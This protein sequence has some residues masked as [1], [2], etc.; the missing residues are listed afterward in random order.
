MAV[1]QRDESFGDAMRPV[2]LRMEEGQELFTVQDSAFQ[3]RCRS[4]RCATCYITQGLSG[5]Y[6]R[7]NGDR[8]AVDAFFG[9]L[10]THIYH[11]N[12]DVESCEYMSRQLGKSRRLRVS[13]S[14]SRKTWVEKLA[15]VGGGGGKGGGGDFSVSS[16]QLP[17]VEPGAFR[18]LKRGGPPDFEVTAYVLLMGQAFASGRH[19]ALVSFSQLP[20]GDAP[21]A[22]TLTSRSSGF[23]SALTLGLSVVRK[24][25]LTL[26][27]WIGNGPNAPR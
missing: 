2:F 9:N 6:A 7:T 15:A 14:A 20:P 12:S 4:A 21:E 5:M 25:A 1:E 19:Y 18:R 16:E 22:P 17:N 3:A 10:S 11:S 26:C 13:G 8:H 23:G 27:S 24:F